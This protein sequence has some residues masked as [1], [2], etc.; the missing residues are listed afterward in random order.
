MSMKLLHQ[1]LPLPL[2]VAALLGGA[3]SISASSPVRIADDM[4]AGPNGT[5]LYFCA[6]ANKPGA[7]TVDNFMKVWHVAKR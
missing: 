3:A 4:L 2:L 6:T 1:P 7:N 5:T